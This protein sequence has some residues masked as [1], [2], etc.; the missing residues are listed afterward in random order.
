MVLFQF[1]KG[2][3]LRP[4]SK[5]VSRKGTNLACKGKYSSTLM[6]CLRA[7]A[8][9]SSNHYSLVRP[10]FEWHKIG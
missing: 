5:K 1:C 9:S 4:V 3:T 8:R 10:L 2:T 6:G 7:R